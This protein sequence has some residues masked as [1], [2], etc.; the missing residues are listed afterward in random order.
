MHS[1]GRMRIAGRVPVQHAADEAAAA[2]HHSAEHSIPKLHDLV[3]HLRRKCA[4]N[5]QAEGAA[6][7]ETISRSWGALGDGIGAGWGV[8]C[9]S[10]RGGLAAV[11]GWA[12]LEPEGLFES[13]AA[14]NVVAFLRAF[15]GRTATVEQC[16]TRVL[17]DNTGADVQ[18]VQQLQHHLE[19]SASSLP[20]VS[21]LFWVNFKAATELVKKLPANP[22]AALPPSPRWLQRRSLQQQASEEL[23]HL[24]EAATTIRLLLRLYEV[25]LVLRKDVVV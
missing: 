17:G 15:F 24:P 8:F 12:E 22:A 4:W 16:C 19:S 25:G 6:N 2:A 7:P 3:E 11:L 1:T 20:A 18:L 5:P 13:N 10:A 14:V 23:L 21:E 9:D